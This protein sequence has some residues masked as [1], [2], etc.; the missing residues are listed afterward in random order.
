[1]TE[2]G[3]DGGGLVPAL[4]IVVAGG[5]AA[6][7][8]TQTNQTGAILAFT[9]AILVAII[10]A[11]TA[12]RRQTKALRAQDQRQR[13]AL[14]AEQARLE[15]RLGHERRLQDVEHLRQ[16][17]DEAA[18]AFET[19]F[20]AH[21]DL[22]S[23]LSTGARN[24][25]YYKGAVEASVGLT[26]MAR[27]VGLRFA[28]DHRVYLRYE[29]TKDAMGAQMTHLSEAVQRLRAADSGEVISEGER[30]RG[31]EM[32]TLAQSKFQEFADAARGE[33]GARA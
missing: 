8:A 23:A 14:Q 10:A 20:E 22:F 25:E 27:R 16:F 32:S 31:E 2:D 6:A 17:L 21:V 5:A 13:E 4:V 7:G 30:K 28:R 1:M 33:V 3:G 11:Y 26:V 29:E 19:A 18:E 24:V 12:N 15:T 9:G